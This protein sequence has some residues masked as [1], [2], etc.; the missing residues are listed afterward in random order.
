MDQREDLSLEAESINIT[1]TSS[2]PR[3]IFIFKKGV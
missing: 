1:I 3:D 2:P